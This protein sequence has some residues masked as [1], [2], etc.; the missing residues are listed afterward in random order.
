MPIRIVSIGL[1]LLALASW[2]NAQE[3][4]KKKPD[5]AITGPASPTAATTSVP[6]AA[7][8]P[9]PT[10]KDVAATTASA[11]VIAVPV[12]KDLSSEF[13]GIRLGMSLDELKSALLGNS[14]FSFRG[15]RDVSLLPAGQQV[16]IE[17]GGLS[18]VKRAFFQLRENRL[19]MM[20]YSLNPETM[21]HYS[22]FSALVEDYGE[23]DSLNPKEAV[24]LSEE[25]RLSV[26]RPLT[27]KYIDRKVF[28]QLALDSRV[29]GTKET[30]LREE[31]LDAF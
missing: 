19:F 13:H 2:S 10:A 16:L 25:V 23:P 28:D 11:P 4:A 31:F 20:A 24:W 1:L 18:F 21:D 30:V 9:L 17:T 14:L 12:E 8:S 6:A 15:D 27:V 22:V 29:T 3:A 7:T 26:E 5:A